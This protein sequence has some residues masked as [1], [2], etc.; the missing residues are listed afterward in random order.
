MSNKYSGFMAEQNKAME[1]LKKQRRDKVKANA[2]KKPM[3]LKRKALI[4]AGVSGLSGIAAYKAMKR[5]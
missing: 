4:L 5:E 2:A 3:S 1:A